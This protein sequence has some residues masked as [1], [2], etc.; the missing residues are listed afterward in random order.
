LRRGQAVQGKL[1]LGGDRDSVVVP[2]GPFLEA[3]GG[4]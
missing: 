2:A 1:E 4:A 3:S